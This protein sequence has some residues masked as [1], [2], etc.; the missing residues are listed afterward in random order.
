LEH[1]GIKVELVG[2]ICLFIYALFILVEMMFDSKYS[3]DFTATSRELE[4]M[5]VFIG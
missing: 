5:G 4:P 1:K 3:S 2:N